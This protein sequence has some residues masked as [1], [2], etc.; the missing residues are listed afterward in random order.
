M[1]VGAI[2]LGLAAFLSAFVAV[3]ICQRRSRITSPPTVVEHEDPTNLSLS[4]TSDPQ[5]LS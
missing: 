3:Y 4:Q 2:V 5:A 1:D